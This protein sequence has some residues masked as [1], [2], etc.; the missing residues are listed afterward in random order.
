MP[1]LI[2][3]ITQPPFLFSDLNVA[4]ESIHLPETFLTSISY[5]DIDS[6]VVPELGVNALMFMDWSVVIVAPPTDIYLFIRVDDVSVGGPVFEFIN[7][8]AQL[9]LQYSVPPIAPVFTAYGTMLVR[10]IRNAEGAIRVSGQL[11]GG[12][13]NLTSA[14]VFRWIALA[15]NS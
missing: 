10:S 12:S 5:T 7:E 8:S 15:N 14:S 4:T 11:S 13:L 2:P 6:W 3:R 9:V 1:Q